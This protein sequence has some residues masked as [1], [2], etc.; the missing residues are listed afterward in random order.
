MRRR[1][2]GFITLNLSIPQPTFLLLFQSLLFSRFKCPSA[3]RMDPNEWAHLYNS[4]AAHNHY[5]MRGSSL[6]AKRGVGGQNIIKRAF[7]FL[8]QQHTLSRRW[9]G[10]CC[11]HSLEFPEHNLLLLLLHQISPLG[12]SESACIF[13]SPRP[14]PWPPGW[15]SLAGFLPPVC[16]WATDERLRSLGGDKLAIYSVALEQVS[17]SRWLK[18]SF[19]YGLAPPETDLHTI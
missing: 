15:D 12:K 3:S 10:D 11:D 2:I 16:V 17:S 14:L 7:T 19:L 1:S 5:D 9:G 13:K 8:Y 6:Q 18:V 4:S